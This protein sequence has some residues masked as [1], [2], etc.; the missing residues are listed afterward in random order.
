[1]TDETVDDA[2]QRIDQW[3]WHSRLVK[4]RTLAARM[5]EG[6]KVRI[7]RNKV[8]KAGYTIKPGD[9]LTFMHG[10]RLRVIEILLTA[11]RRGPASE[12]RTL[13]RDLTEP[14]CEQSTHGDRKGG[15][16]A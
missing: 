6:G 13:Y 5:V 9:T 10:G 16:Q 11:T 8:R 14:D 7:N 3:L 1:M 4:T 12:A 15:V 2:R